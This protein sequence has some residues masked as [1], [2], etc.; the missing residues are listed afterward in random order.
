MCGE[1]EEEREQREEWDERE[2]MPIADQD[3][4]ADLANPPIG[5]HILHDDL[6]PPPRPPATRPCPAPYHVA[7]ALHV[8]ARTHMPHP[9]VRRRRTFGG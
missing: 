9:L 5:P 7:D 8:S 6:E 3:T 2:G 1:R 4:C